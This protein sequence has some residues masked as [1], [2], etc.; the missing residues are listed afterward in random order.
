MA[1]TAQKSAQETNRTAL[2][3]VLNPA[4]DWKGKTRK[5][6]FS[7]TQAGAGDANSTVD[8][9]TLPPGK[10]RLLKTESL[11]VCSAFGAARVLDVGYL[12]HTK[13]DGTAV[14]AAADVIDDGADASAAASK[15]MGT[16][17]NGLGTDPTIL[18]DSRDG[19][20]I[21]AKVLGGTIPDLATLN[22]YI[23]AIA[24]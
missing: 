5:F 21:Q 3:P 20:T 11:Y 4:Y 19:V 24:E 16:G 7:H 2:P 10:W 9:V 8:L 23:T 18:F 1:V 12:A 17:T 15:R 14:N 22:G 6:Y 13:I